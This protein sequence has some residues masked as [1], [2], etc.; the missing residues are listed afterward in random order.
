M[1]RSFGRTGSSRF[2]TALIEDRKLL[3]CFVTAVSF[4]SQQRHL[5]AQSSGVPRQLAAAA[6]N[7][8]TGNN[9]WEG[10]TAVC[11]SNRSG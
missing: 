6:N 11:C 7:P 8:M 3:S 2:A 9:D 5:K 1:L 10:I 4:Q